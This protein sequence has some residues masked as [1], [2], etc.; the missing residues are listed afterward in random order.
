LN[1][2]SEVEDSFSGSSSSWRFL[3]SCPPSTDWGFE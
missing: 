3:I 1:L 2:N